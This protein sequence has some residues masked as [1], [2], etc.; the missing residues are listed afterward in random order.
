MRENQDENREK[1]PAEGK[2]QFILV[3]GII[4]WG[5]PLGI[6][7]FVLMRAFDY[8]FIR[9]PFPESDKILI[10]KFIFSLLLWSLYGYIFTSWQWNKMKKESLSK[11][12]ENK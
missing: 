5:L 2:F 1:I 8:F 6:T 3:R 7:Y 11:D 10:A 9:S 12:F 4:F